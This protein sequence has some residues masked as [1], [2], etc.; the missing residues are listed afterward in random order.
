MPG[1][2]NW[3]E[4]WFGSDLTQTSV[5]NTGINMPAV[6]IR[7]NDESFVVEMAA[8]GMTKEDFNIN[9]DNNLLTISSEKETERE[10]EGRDN[11]T[12][13]EFSY[14]AFTRTFTLPNTVNG[15]AIAA[16][17]DN[18]ILHLTL[19]KKEEARRKPPKAIEIK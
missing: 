12:R 19:P 2:Y 18:G 14:T 6:N 13:K 1:F 4:D 8:P 17:Y 9:L 7:E 15:E 10:T 16:Q 3:I 5:F 11:Y